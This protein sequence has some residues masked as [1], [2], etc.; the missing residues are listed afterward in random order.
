MSGVACT[1]C[2]GRTGVRDSR[3]TTGGIRRR[4]ICLTCG[5]RLTTMEVVVGAAENDAMAASIAAVQ[6]AHGL[7]SAVNSLLRSF[8][9]GLGMS[10]ERQQA[11]TK[12][13]I[14]NGRAA[15]LSLPGRT[16]ISSKENPVALYDEARNK[17]LTDG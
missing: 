17:V 12:M 2:G 11:L 13:L 15:A 7:D 4:R 10:A 1:N 16:G 6:L 3:P 8:M 9:N 14:S 5:A